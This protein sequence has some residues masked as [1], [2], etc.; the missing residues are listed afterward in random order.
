MLVHT[1]VHRRHL[2]A[3]TALTLSAS[4]WAAGFERGPAPTEAGLLGNGPY[5]VA[6]AKVASPAGFGSATVYYPTQTQE[7]KFGLV[8]LAPGFLST[9]GLYTWLASRLASHGFVVVNMG[10]KTVFDTPEPRGVQL[11]AALKQVSTLVAAGTV[12]YAAITDTARQAIMGHSAGGGGTLTAA[13]DNPGLKAA[14]PMTPAS[15]VSSFDTVAVPT[16]ILACEKDA[17][18]PNATFSAKYYPTLPSTLDR[19]YLEIAGADHLCPTS[20]AKAAV[21]NTVART[22]IPWLKRHVDEDRRYQG[23]ITGAASPTYVKVDVH[24]SP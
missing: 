11:M 3:A 20:L 4:A 8:G 16:L 13:R 17:I 10:T 5:T 18:A 22:V 6:S 24:L 14:I 7:G 12:P 15:N 23:F 2:L 19:A 21:Q 9:P 1:S